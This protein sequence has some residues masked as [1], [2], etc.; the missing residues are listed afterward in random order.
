[1]SPNSE[2]LIEALKV[3]DPS[4]AKRAL[5]D[6]F[7]RAKREAE[8]ESLYV[9]E[10]GRFPLTAVGDVNTYALFA[11]L[12]YRL[13]S[14]SGRAGII[15]PSGIATDD[16]T[17]AFFEEMAGS[18]QLVSLYDFENR[19]AI[20]PSVHRSY[21]F[22]LLTLGSGALRTRF[23]FFATNVGHL[24]DE[25]RRFL[26]SEKD[27][28]LINPNTRTCP[29]FRSGI[30]AELTKKI[31]RRVPVLIDETKGK[32]GNPWG[33]RF[34][35]MFHMS[36]DS[37]LFRTAEAFRKAGARQEGANWI[38]ADGEVW[39]PLYEAKMIHQYD[40]RWATYDLDGE[41]ARDVTEPEK[42]DGG[43]QVL[44]RYWVRQ[45]EV[46]ERLIKYDRDGNV[47]W[48][49]EKDWLLG[50]RDITNA[51]NERTVIAGVIPRVGVGNNM[52]L[53]FA[54]SNIK[55]W[56]SAML[57]TNLSTM[58]FDFFARHKVGGTHLNFFL[59]KQLP[60]L[61]P[62]SYDMSDTEFIVPRLLELSYITTDLSPFAQ[63]LGFLGPPFKYD[64]D[65]RAVLRAELDAYFARLYGLTR[66]ELRYI[67]DPT[68]VYGEDFPSETFRVLKNNEIKQFGEY[69][70]RRLVL[71]AWDRQEKTEKR[72][73][74]A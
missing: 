41:T 14:E 29:V 1:L 18:R 60:V 71:E 43:F 46:D 53:F 40:H 23:V 47:T 21:K 26:L 62:S 24:A 7:Q 12:F 57:L 25:Q 63:D 28:Q 5:Y 22:C 61:P 39:V 4:S 33:I 72:V 59:I 69:R 48:S 45:E 16:N 42:A 31:Y 67:L 51:T 13:K 52:P 44:P 27:I 37:H 10:S 74:F 68:D 19:E 58:V 64:I 34:M 50:W 8:A 70:T 55:P 3:T 32:E 56:L 9:R 2:R 20:F 35:T 66:D 65:R 36:N 49:W 11:E 73:S 15:V 17:K 6:A 38:A 54:S 30:D